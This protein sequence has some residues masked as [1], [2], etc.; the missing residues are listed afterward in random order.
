MIDELTTLIGQ[1]AGDPAIRGLVL[2]GKPGYFTAGLDLVSL[3][4]LNEE[5]VL[6]FWS[7]FL[8]LIRQ[9]VVFPKPSVAAIAGHS[10]AGGCALAICCDYRVMAEG[11]FV[12][13]LNELPVGIV[14]P[15]LIFHL[16]A[17]W[18]GQAEAYRCLLEGRLM[19]PAEAEACGL[20]DE[21]VPG[22]RVQGTATKQLK[23]YMQ[24]DT[25]SWS[26]SKLNLRRNL[27]EQIDKDPSADIASIV[28]HW[29]KPSTRSLL[30]SIIDNLKSK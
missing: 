20:V 15:E 13:G 27:I 30:K 28:E 23:K 2:H 29:W 26:A 24:F 18:I 1:L 3:F 7:K 12:I 9:L 14:V 21:I 17:F 4:E 8:G 5:E 16:Y 19:S 22:D 25:G 6:R 10:P 11:D